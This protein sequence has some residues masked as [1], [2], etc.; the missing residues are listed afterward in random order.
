MKKGI[1]PQYAP[2][3]I[4]CAC[5]SV[6]ETRSTKDNL[7]VQICSSCHPFYTGKQ[8]LVD[9]AG[10]IDRFARKFSGK[11]VSAQKMQKTV[12]PP[13]V[14]KEKEKDKEAA[15]KKDAK[16]QEAPAKAEE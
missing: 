9:A 12:A 11:T 1:H 15:P 3:E 14:K 7:T 16:K 4:R 6:I 10:R 2:T 5:G 8:K 13:P